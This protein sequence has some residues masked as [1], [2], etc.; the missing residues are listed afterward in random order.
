MKI[1]F[2]LDIYD[3]KIKSNTQFT[4]YGKLCVAFS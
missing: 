2:L 1:F 4:I 3:A